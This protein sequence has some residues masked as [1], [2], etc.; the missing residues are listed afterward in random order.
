MCPPGYYQ[1]A[2]G[3]MVTHAFGH[4]MYGYTLYIKQ[5]II[6]GVLR[7][8]YFHLVDIFRLMKNQ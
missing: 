2:N 4:M 1:S 8:A 5:N 6:M 7:K 3:P